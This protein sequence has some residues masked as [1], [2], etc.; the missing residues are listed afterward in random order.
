MINIAIR[1]AA[2][3]HKAKPHDRFPANDDT[4]VNKHA[5]DV[6]MGTLFVP[7]EDAF[8]TPVRETYRRKL[9]DTRNAIAHK[10]SVAGFEGYLHVG[11]YEDGTP[12][13]IFIK[14]SKQGSTV[15]GLCDTI[16]IL[17]SMC[18][19][20]GVPVASLAD[21]LRGMSFDPRGFTH[22]PDIRTATSLVDYIGRFLE[23]KYG[24]KDG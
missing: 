12:G 13:E 14:I 18:L 7:E 19:Q 23:L 2:A 10:F 22:N 1:E 17:L 8:P 4:G 20:S 16:A 21:K 3:M 9:P 11:L 15:A 6:G 24:P 5:D